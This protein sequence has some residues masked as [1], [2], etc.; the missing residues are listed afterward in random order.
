MHVNR[1][2]TGIIK[3][4]ADNEMHWSKEISSKAEQTKLTTCTS[5]ASRKGMKQ[6]ITNM[7]DD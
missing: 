7:R 5:M 6:L 4:T 2:G 3:K 1:N